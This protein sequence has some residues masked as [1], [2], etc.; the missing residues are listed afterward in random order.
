MGRGICIGVSY[1]VQRF[2]SLYMVALGKALKDIKPNK[3]HDA[4]QGG[5]LTALSRRVADPK[6]RER[7][8]QQGIR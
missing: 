3:D 6:D 5:D 8:I 2:Q 7:L 1:T 4:M